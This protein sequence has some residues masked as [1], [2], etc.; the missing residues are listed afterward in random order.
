MINKK[1]QKKKRQ[2]RIRK[3]ISGTSQ[4]PRLSVFKSNKYMYAQL[5]DD[6][7][8]TTIAAANDKNIKTSKEDKQKKITSAQELGEKLAKLAQDKKVK[9]IVFDRSGHR[10]HGRIKALADAARKGGLSF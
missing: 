4:I 1:E 10:Y 9:K 7:S 3:N 2:Y 6:L 5:I 8:G